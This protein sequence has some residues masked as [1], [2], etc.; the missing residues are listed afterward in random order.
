MIGRRTPALVIAAL[1]LAG[2]AGFWAPSARSQMTAMPSWIPIGVSASANG[3]TV[4]FHEPHS[5]QAL[6]CHS[7]ASGTTNA[8]SIACAAAK[9][10]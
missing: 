6:A 4:W 7:V 9:L 1:S 8:P 2:A 10:P 5:R 3:S